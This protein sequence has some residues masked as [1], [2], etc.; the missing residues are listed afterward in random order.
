MKKSWWKFLGAVA[1]LVALDMATTDRSGWNYVPPSRAAPKG[2][3]VVAIATTED[4]DPPVPID[5]YPVTYEQVR[6]VVW[7]ALDLDTSERNI[8]K[9]IEPDDWVAVKIN[10]V[11]APIVDGSGRKR[12]GF[13][14]DGVEHWGDCTDLRVVK[15]VLEYLI[16]NVG[17]RKID[18]V[19]GPAEWSRKN[20]RHLGAAYGNSYDTDGWEIQWREFGNLSP[21]QIAR[22]FNEKYGK[23]I[24]DTTDL[25]DEAYRFEPVPG[26]PL[27]RVSPQWRD[28]DRFGWGVPVP[29]TGTPREG[30]Y[31]PVTVLDADKMISI[32]V[33]KTNYGG[34]TLAMKNYVGTLSSRP[35]G[36]GTSKRQMDS[37]QYERGFVD[38]FSYNPAVYS[39]IEGFW[40]DEGSWPGTRWNLHRNMVIASS[41]PV[42]A[43]AVALA[44][45]G[46]NPRDVDH[47]YLAA[48]KGFGTFDL[49]RIR[50]VGRSWREVQ[51]KF[52]RHR[53]FR[54]LG[55][56]RWLVAGPFEGTDLDHDYI[57][58]EATAIP[59]TGDPAG[60]GGT[61]RV[62]MHPPTYPETYVDL[63]YYVHQEPSR[64][65]FPVIDIKRDLGNTTHYA[66]L[67]IESKGDQD[68]YLWVDMDDM[69]KVWLNGEEVFRKDFPSSYKIG[70]YRVPVHLRD[71]VN[72]LMV[73]VANTYGGAGFCASIVDEDSERG[74]M[75]FDIRDF[76]PGEAPAVAEDE[77]GP[78]PEQFELL[79]NFPNPF[80][81]ST[82]IRV[83]VARREAVY[84]EVYDMLGR[85]VCTLADGVLLPPGEYTYT[86]DGRDGVGVPVASGVYLCTLRAG[87]FSQT[88]R[89]VLV[90]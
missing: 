33:M 31:M 61:W 12:T 35:F 83:Q 5:A 60:E 57:G 73:K 43:D 69:G 26:G 39:I 8:R 16:E 51:Y 87:N 48:Y 58:G 52:R 3:P 85:M 88:R 6:E 29:F 49:D 10:M 62:W 20:L 76:L 30:Y 72:T 79:G 36:D 81:A 38:L 41:D 25:N 24:V 82:Q 13:W 65:E 59:R 77:T 80:N 4:L 44:A 74:T 32:A 53:G 45:M 75:L 84:L 28:S 86:W 78:L 2:A 56:Q 40:A 70:Q 90:R 47:L 55:F 14:R 21:I 63:T 66:F 71:G 67:L 42:A 23:T 7:R 11:T 19:E 50:T 37:N 18:I 89:M 64:E 54:G 46:I 22:E 9:V 17:P 27:Q 68:G 34:A 1:G 15:A